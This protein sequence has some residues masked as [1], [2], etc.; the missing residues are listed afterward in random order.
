M[1]DQLIVHS[2]SPYNAEPPLAQLRAS[3]VTAQTDFYVRSHGNVPQISLE[4]FTLVVD[5]LVGK[6][7]QLSMEN[8]AGFAEQNIEA[9]MQCAG[10]RRADMQAVRPVS[11]D[12]WDAGAIGN[13]KWSGVSLAEVLDAPGI[14]RER[15]RHVAFHALDDCD[16]DGKQFRY[17]ASI[18]IEKA[19]SGDVLL[20][21]AMNDEPLAP[22]HGFPLR[23][24]VPG[25][26]GV[27]SPKWLCRIEVREQPSDCP[28]QA[29]DYKLLPPYIT[30]TDAIDWARGVTINDLPVNSAICEPPAYAKLPPGTATLRGWA[31][32][33]GRAVARVDAS[34][35]GGR[36]WH[37]AKIESAA[38]PWAWTFWS[39]E[40]ELSKGEHELVV[41]A[42]D[43]A[44]QTQPASPDDTWNVKGYLSAAWH[45]VRVPVG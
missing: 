22:E 40:V 27:R 34:I 43:D 12:P 25:Y 31:M 17:A 13:A 36:S 38:S 1:T 6:P 4:T 32:A 19:L 14:D 18:P 35:D 20:A 21:T 26:A 29:E 37:Q 23:V 44:G 39:I 30:S 42:W 15:A 24:V 9:V 33:T 8:L 41:R 3:Y 7:L 16:V 2:K 45:R 5:G 28:I 11:G 10:N